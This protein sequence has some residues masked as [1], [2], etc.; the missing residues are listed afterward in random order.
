MNTEKSVLLAEIANFLKKTKMT[1]LQ[2]FSFL[3]ISDDFSHFRECFFVESV[4]N[5][6]A[7]PEL[8][9]WSASKDWQVLTKNSKNVKKRPPVA[10]LSPQSP[11]AFIGALVYR[12]IPSDLRPMPEQFHQLPDALIS[13]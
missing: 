11:N 12:G 6:V 10:P 1:N 2:Y 4:P 3:R 13:R 5:P 7:M 8:F 9:N